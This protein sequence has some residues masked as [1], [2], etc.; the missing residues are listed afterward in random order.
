MNQ[1][2]LERIPQ[3]AERAITPLG[4]IQDALRKNVAPEVLKELVS[5]Q[6]SMVRFEWEAQERQSKID[7]DDALTACQMAIAR[8]RPDRQNTQTSSWYAT[9]AKLDRIVRPIYTREGFSISFGEKDCPVQGKIRV[10][11]YVSRSGITRE[12][13]KDVTPPL[14]GPKGNPVMTATHGDGAA[15]SYAK[16]YLLQDIFNI[17]IG[18]DAEDNDGNSPQQISPDTEARLQE[19][20]DALRQCDDIATLKGIFADA[21]KFAKSVSDGEKRR[22]TAT[23]E[24]LKKKLG[25]GQ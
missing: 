15:N 3:D 19:W 12:Y 14:L 18:I 9:Y 11:A 17:A 16:R 2:A 6:Q 13:L 10:V 5:L 25:G 1:V 23:Y 21:Y 4:L 20:E 7:F 8:V 24:E 22:M